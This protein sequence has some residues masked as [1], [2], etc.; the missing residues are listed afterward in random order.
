MSKIL[1]LHRDNAGRTKQPVNLVRNAAEASLYIYDMIDAYWGVS[2]L[3]VIDA[4]NRA[5]DA[6]VLHVYINSPGGDVFEGRAIM[7]ALSRFTGKTIAHIDSLCASAATSIALACNEVEMSAGSFFMIHN[8]SGI[9][10]GDKS[11][12]R[13]T[14]DLLEKIEGSI[15]ADY[16]A[17]TGKDAEQ[18]VAW[19]DAESWFTADEALEHGFI[20]RITAAPVSSGKAGN[21]WNLAAYAK[22]PAALT[23]APAPAEPPAAPTPA[24]TNA[25]PPAPAAEPVIEQPAAPAAPEPSMTQANKNRLAL[26]LAL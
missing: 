11:A 17:K 26:A 3:S 14:A 9:A 2:A 15:V 19:M 5:G 24:P 25:S 4:V 1:Q 20:D 23:A 7:A 8:A 22:A 16:T 12:M 21:A 13:E 10:W 6:E 18:I